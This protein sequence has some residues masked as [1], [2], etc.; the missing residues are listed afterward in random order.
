MAV[1]WG[2]VELA[3]GDHPAAFCAD[4]SP[5]S[6]LSAYTRG[7]FPFPAADEFQRDLNE[8]GCEDLVNDG[9]IALL[10]DGD[11][12]QVAWWA[13]DPRPV[14]PVGG[15]HLGRDIRKRLRRVE[16]RTTADTAFNH[17]VLTCRDGREPR[18]LTGALVDTLQALHEDGWAHSIEVWD[19][20]DLVGGAFGIGA[21]RV[22]SGDS[23]FARQPGAA[24]IAV[25][26]LAER[27]GRGGGLLVDAQWDSPF[28][29][30]LGAEPMPRERYIAAVAP[31]R[32][33]LPAEPL[34]ARRLLPLAGQARPRQ[35]RTGPLARKVTGDPAG[36]SQPPSVRTMKSGISGRFS[37]L[38]Y[39]TASCPW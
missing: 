36:S 4:V 28:L 2:C 23:L 7:L 19:G 14:I 13:P 37:D 8:F 34:P 39:T 11:P 20:E 12:Y 3:A 5:D 10:G 17:V 18:W 24:R 38:T 9:R 30:S 26:D 35:T 22:L 1:D 33:R 32:V 21:G 31:E 6:V 29:R 27:L 16:H 25:A 15:V